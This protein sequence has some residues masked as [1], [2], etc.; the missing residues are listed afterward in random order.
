MKLID[1]GKAT[2]ETKMT[3]TFGSAFD[4]TYGPQKWF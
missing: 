4:N 2:V 1:L 3:M